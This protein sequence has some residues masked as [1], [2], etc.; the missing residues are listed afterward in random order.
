MQITMKEVDNLN[1]CKDVKNTGK[2]YLLGSFY[3]ENEGG[4]FL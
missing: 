4:L 3:L 2:E 1:L